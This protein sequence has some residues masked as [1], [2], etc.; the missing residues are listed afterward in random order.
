MKPV[1]LAAVLQKRLYLSILGILRLVPLLGGHR[2]SHKPDSVELGHWLWIPERRTVTGWRPWGPLKLEGQRC[3]PLP[4]LF[5]FD[6]SSVEN[7][8]L[9]APKT[10]FRR[11]TPVGSPFEGGIRTGL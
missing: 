5:P 6:S 3:L 1:L 2:A 9:T 8:R 11:K 10:S 7:D 4:V